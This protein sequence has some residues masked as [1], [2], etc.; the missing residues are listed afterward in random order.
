MIKVDIKSKTFDNNQTIL[1]D[2]NFEISPGEL[3]C[4]LG[5]SGTGK[6]TL[7]N[8]V[9]GIDTRYE[10][11]VS[12]ARCAYAF[13]EP[14]LL[15]W[16]T[17]RQN[18]ELVKN[19]PEKIDELLKMSGLSEAQNQFPTRISLG[20]ARRAALA[21]CLLVE[22][23]LV[24]M[25]EP[26]VSLDMTMANAMRQQLQLMRKKHPLLAV[27][28]ITHDIDEAVELADRIIILSGSPATIQRDIREKAS[29]ELINQYLTSN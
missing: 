18:L 1:S 24:L 16:R 8:I 6:T 27:L 14:R 28:Y 7:L 3:I 15:P 23:E 10:G 19:D 17:L 4:V 13:Q 11:S 9:A 20:M 21:R 25:D 5:S 29:K 12:K 2:I 22:P 26:M